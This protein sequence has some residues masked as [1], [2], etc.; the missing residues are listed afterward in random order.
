MEIFKG[1]II[2]AIQEYDCQDISLFKI[3]GLNLFSANCRVP[4]EFQG[5][6]NSP[7]IVTIEGL[8]DR[9]AFSV[10]IGYPAIENWSN[11]VYRQS[12]EKVSI[13]NIINE[14]TD[15]KEVLVSYY[16][17]SFDLMMDS[18]YSLLLKLNSPSVLPKLVNSFLLWDSL[19]FFMSSDAGFAFKNLPKLLMGN[20]GILVEPLCDIVDFF[21]VSKGEGQHLEVY[22]RDAKI[23]DAVIRACKGAEKFIERTKWYANNKDHLFWDN[24]TDQ[25]LKVGDYGGRGLWGT[26]IGL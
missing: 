8:V 20:D 12:G 26:Y 3:Y 5:E 4:D 6:E 15:R 14:S 13:N 11:D 18:K 22:S 7:I 16:D 19:V 9:R 24:D 25:C 10:L 21:V 2:K 1:N 17:G 23:K